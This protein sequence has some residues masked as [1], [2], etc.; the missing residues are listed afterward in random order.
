MPVPFLDVEI[1]RVAAQLHP[2]LLVHDGYLKYSYRMIQPD[3]PTEVRFN[4]TKRGFWETH[5]DRYPWMP[6]L[7]H[8]LCLESPAL[9]GAFPKLEAGLDRV[10]LDQWWRLVQIALLDS[11]GVS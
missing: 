3:I 8:D 6:K 4:T 5:P 7:S 11:V 9:R 10:S 2:A 1:N